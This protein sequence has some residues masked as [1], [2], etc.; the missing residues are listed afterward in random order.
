[1]SS[2]V[3]QPNANEAHHA[4][5][6]AKGFKRWLYTTNH[7][8]IGSL[9]LIFSLTMFLIGG[10]MAMVIRAELFQPGLQ[11][12]DPHFFNQMT[13]VHGLIMV[14]GAVMP[15]FTGLANWMIPLMIGAPDM[16]LP[17]M[18]NWSFWI[19]PF[20]FLILLASLFMPGGGPAFGWTFYAPL[21]TTYSNDN[22]ALF[23][24][25]VHIMGISSIM[26]AINVIV[27]IVNLRAPGM[28]WMKLPLFVWTWLITAF[29]LI[30]VM[31]VLAGAVTMVLT[32][33]Y[34]ATSF[35]D[36][37]GGGDPVMFQHIFWFF[38]HPEVYIMIL[39]A[40][41][42]IS[43][44][45]PTFSRKKLFGY[46]S[47]VYAT[48]SI[49]LLSFIV[50]AHHMFTTGMP[51]AGELFFMYATMLISVPT[52][53][54]VFNWV[55]TM[56]KGSIT[57]EVPMLFSIAFI[58]LFTLG[59]F[60]GLMLAITPADFQYHDTYF[61][62]A[63]FHYVLVTGAVFSIMA[64]AYYW[65]P[66]WTGNMFNITLAKWHFWLS[67]VSVNVLFFPMH[68]VGLAGMPRRI[69]DY[70]LQ[71]ADFNAIISIGGFAFGLSQLLFV[72]VVIKCARGGDK[73]PAKVWEG[74]EGLEWEV[75]SPA[76][77]HTFSTPPVIK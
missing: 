27:T 57:F 74:A 45:V 9:Y 15:A 61:V 14:F 76:P 54:K 50:W 53:V 5:H 6:P 69:P 28:T 39:P 2:I 67:L 68:F 30:A 35:F 47:M 20:A 36:A 25:A 48:S 56:W 3:E 51:V 65:L 77:Y 29:L 38:G 19:L 1:M 60:S 71:F 13:T 37:A 63:H 62:V 70:A 49:A 43:T 72:A 17:R 42:I 64:G 66:K 58:V 75:D 24:F 41:G 23:V 4:H 7:K 11:L 59:G 22:T 10:G 18:N 8:D 21:S 16:A 52:G 55:A 73:V 26:G 40:F 31:P 44:I 32:D 34:F 46:A 33:K 12:V